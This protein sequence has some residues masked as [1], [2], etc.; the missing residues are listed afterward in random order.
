MLKVPA[1]FELA[2]MVSVPAGFCAVSETLPSVAAA[3]VSNVAAPPMARAVA[4]C[5]VIAA[6]LK[7]ENAP[8]VLTLPSASAPVLRTVAPPEVVLATDNAAVAVS[9]SMPLAAES[10]TVGAVTLTVPAPF[11]SVIAPAVAASVTELVAVK[12]ETARLPLA[13][14]TLML[15]SVPA[16]VPPVRL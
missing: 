11:A 15:A 9:M 1:I 3:E 13:C 12:V 7:S 4:P 8:A 14:V 6:L 2:A 10:A 16:K 5:W